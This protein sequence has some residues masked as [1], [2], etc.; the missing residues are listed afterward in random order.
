MLAYELQKRFRD[1]NDHIAAVCFDPGPLMTAWDLYRREENRWPGTGMAQGDK[2]MLAYFTRVVQDPES[3]AELPVTLATTCSALPS[4]KPQV[5]YTGYWEL[6]LPAL[7]K[8][9]LPWN[10]SSSY[11]EVLWST[12]WDR[13]ERLVQDT[14]HHSG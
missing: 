5:G 8:F 6:G 2:D 13:S 10:W 3:A 11:D 4:Q 12:L 14:L 7:S 1:A 9:P